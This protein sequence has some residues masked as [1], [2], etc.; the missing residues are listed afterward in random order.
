MLLSLTATWSFVLGV[1]HTFLVLDSLLLI[2]VRP[3]R[4]T[5]DPYLFIAPRTI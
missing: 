2:V 1:L 3:E 4:S 5:G